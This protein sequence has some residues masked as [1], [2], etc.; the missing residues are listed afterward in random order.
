MRHIAQA[1]EA[2]R[3]IPTGQAPCGRCRRGQA[4]HLIDPHLV[5]CQSCATE[6]K[7]MSPRQR[8]ELRGTFGRGQS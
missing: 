7:R 2:V 6:W 3:G 8:F 5:V 4:T 1:I